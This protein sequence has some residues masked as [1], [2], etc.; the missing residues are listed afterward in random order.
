MELTRKQLLAG[1]AAAAAGTALAGCGGGSAPA[2]TTAT[3]GAPARRP[4]PLSSWPGVRAQL[5]LDPR[6]RHFAAFLLAPHPRP[7]REAIERHRRGLD[8]D[9]AGYLR[10]TEG[11]A[12]VAGAAARYLGARR[13]DVALTGSTTMGL[14]ILYRGLRLR[15]G[16]EILSTTHDHFATDEA[17]RLS[18]GRVRRVRLYDAAARASVDE[19]AS[20]LRR[21]IG[22]RTR[23]VALTWVHSSTGVKLPMGAIADVVR[24]AGRRR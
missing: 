22:P 2:A 4:E 9:P 17:L 20:R 12:D 10:A 6:L 19:I 5:G 18:G 23:A 7:V 21:A 15:E 11:R 3:G 13:D 16:E 1:G 24:D 8:A 14:A